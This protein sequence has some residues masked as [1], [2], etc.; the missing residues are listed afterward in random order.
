[1]A[2]DGQGGQWV[3]YGSYGTKNPGV[4]RMRLDGSGA[5]RVLAGTFKD[6]ATSPDGKHVAFIDVSEPN[7]ARLRIARIADGAFDTFVLD[8]QVN[9]A[10]GVA[11]F[12]LRFTPDGRSVMFGG[13]DPAGPSAMWIQAFEPGRDTTSTRRRIALFDAAQTV[14]TFAIS[15]DGR[16]VIVSA[17]ERPSDLVL[18][19]GLAGV[20]R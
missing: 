13:F 11:G 9:P 4:W 7:H 16:R 19:E 14:E 17:T 3:F 20:R 1:M 10:A 5:E 6:P 2:P 18:V 12:R 8:V 15:P